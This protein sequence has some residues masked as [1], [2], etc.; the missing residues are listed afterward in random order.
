MYTK[1]KLDWIEGCLSSGVLAFDV[2]AKLD[3]G[4]SDS[5][6]VIDLQNNF[7]R[8]CICRTTA[9]EHFLEPTLQG[10]NVFKVPRGGVVETKENRDRLARAP[11]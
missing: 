8:L 1:T 5:G 10:T 6:E 7:E 11:P 3:K 4:L 9:G 2:K